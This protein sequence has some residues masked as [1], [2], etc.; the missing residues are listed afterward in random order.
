[1]GSKHLRKEQSQAA[2]KCEV[3]GSNN[4][5]VEFAEYLI[6]WT[7]LGTLF[8][9][10]SIDFSVILPFHGVVLMATKGKGI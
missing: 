4:T 9:Y 10:Q 2:K 6:E 8:Y 3:F 5:P 1:M 7:C